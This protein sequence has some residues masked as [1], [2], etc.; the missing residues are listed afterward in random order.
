M[1][2][3]IFVISGAPVALLAVLGLSPL[4]PIPAWA[5][6]PK[7]GQRV[8]VFCYV[9]PDSSGFVDQRSKELQDSLKDLQ[10]A[11][12]KKKPGSSR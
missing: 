3:R 1:Q 9:E 10:Q 5:D 7:P 2:R 11:L 6:D 8:R 12:A 4:F